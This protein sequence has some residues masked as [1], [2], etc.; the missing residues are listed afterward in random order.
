MDATKDW[1]IAI[2]PSGKRLT[3]SPSN[4]DLFV[5][6]DQVVLREVRNGKFGPA[7]QWR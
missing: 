1:P 6:P 4:H 7:L 5:S 3:F 2:G